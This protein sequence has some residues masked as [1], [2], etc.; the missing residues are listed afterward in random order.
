[1]P[2]TA[3]GDQIPQLQAAISHLPYDPI[4]DDGIHLTLGRIGDTETTSLRAVH[5]LLGAIRAGM[6]TA[7]DL[8]AIP[9]TASRG[10]VRYSI[11]PWTPLLALHAHLAQ[12]TAGAGLGLMKPT[13]HLRPH[14]GVA[15]SSRRCPAAD[16]R[17]V[18][19]PLRKL[20]PSTLHVT[21]VDLVMM[22]READ[23][24]RWD[25]VEEAPLA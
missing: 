9:I 24:Y 17:T 13:S 15:Y 6:S 2:T 8:T 1:M 16:V 7:F 18:L 3:F 14:V 10:A 12:A 19:A 5:E 22:R 23:A 25:T 21:K 20:P 11:A 4:P